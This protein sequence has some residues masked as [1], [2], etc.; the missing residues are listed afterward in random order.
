MRNPWKTKKLRYIIA[1]L[2]LFVIAG[3]IFL[4]RSPVLIVT[5]PSFN[6]IYGPQRLRNRAVFVSL[7]LF[8]RV[9][10]V[11]VA[12]NAASDLITI[13]LE[14]VSGSP[15]AV[16]F[17]YRYFQAALLYREKYPQTQVLVMGGKN[18]P[19]ES[20]PQEGVTY[21][22]TDLAADLYRAG[23]SAAVLAGETAGALFFSDGILQE[24]YRE[25]FRQG[26]RAQDFLTD[27]VFLAS[28]IDHVNYSDIGSVVVA[29]P[30][31]NFLERELDI[32]VIL[33]SWIDPALTPRSVKI[34]FDD[35]P[36]ALAARALEVF[37]PPSG[38]ILVASRPEVLS[39]RLERRR[40]IRKLQ[41]F[42]KE[43]P[44]KS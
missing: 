13:A 27:P 36:L 17:P 14:G 6:R 33:F 22:R 8:R 5:D 43:K 3:G 16:L 21:V 11:P 31:V 34:I 44:E 30:A 32:P 12:E 9:R 41:R 20:F 18:P 24:Q 25:A 23:L 26:L 19:P 38:E 1:A 39:G 15:H 29:G 42:I 28:H 4:L 40:D 2:L 35:S 37:P 10:T 7:E